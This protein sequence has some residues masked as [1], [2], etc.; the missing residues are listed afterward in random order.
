MI[1]GHLGGKMV[2]P[3]SNPRQNTRRYQ[4]IDGWVLTVVECK[5]TKEQQES[6]ILQDSVRE[7]LKPD[8]LEVGASARKDD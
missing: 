3:F 1:F 5:P 7:S 2:L 8:S 4:I 6:Q